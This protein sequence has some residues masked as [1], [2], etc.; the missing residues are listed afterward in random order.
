MNAYWV[1]DVQLNSSKTFLGK[2]GLSHTFNVLNSKNASLFGGSKHFENWVAV[3]Q[4]TRKKRVVLAESEDIVVSEKIQIDSY[5]K[6]VG[7][8][9]VVSIKVKGLPKGYKKDDLKYSI[10]DTTIASVSSSGDIKGIKEGATIVHI[11]TKDDVY[12][13]QCQILVPIPTEKS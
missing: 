11:S 4:C 3:D 6:I 2:L 7:I 5:S 10:E 13:I 12:E 1:G 9:D 8:G